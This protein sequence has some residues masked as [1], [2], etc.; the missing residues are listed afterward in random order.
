MRPEDP[1]AGSQVPA[2]RGGGEL[3]ARAQGAPGTAGPPGPRPGTSSGAGRP[4][5]LTPTPL[6]GERAARI[7]LSLPRGASGATPEAAVAT[8]HITD[9]GDVSDSH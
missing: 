8:H 3:G 7:S 5:P 4:P 9:G 6:R 2:Q 1:R